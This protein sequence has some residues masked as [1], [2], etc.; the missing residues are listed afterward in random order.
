MSKFSSYRSLTPAGLLLTVSLAACS[1]ARTAE[2]AVA[3]MPALPPPPMAE[4]V[5]TNAPVT[6]PA[7]DSSASAPEPAA[8][9]DQGKGSWAVGK[10]ADAALVAKVMADTGATKTRMLKPGM[11]VTAEFDGGRVDIRVDNNNVVLAVTCG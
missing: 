5:A 10:V 1:S 4:P 9:C 3:G 8:A 7:S 6:E 11:M 2:P